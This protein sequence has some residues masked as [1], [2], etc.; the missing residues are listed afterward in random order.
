MTRTTRPAALPMYATAAGLTLLGTLAGCADAGATAGG[1]TPGDTSASYADGSYQ[2]NGTYTSPNGSE[3][4]IVAVT[5]EDDVV[6]E[7]EVTTNP[8]N[9]T[10]EFY[11]SAFAEGIAAEAVGV[12]IDLLDVT[13]V[14]G[15]SLTSGGFREAIASIKADALE[16]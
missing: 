14:S 11:Q 8:N 9:P 16:G 15:S 2:A 12:D 7:V 5:L 4:I 10:T 1:T 6:T 3:N 13:R